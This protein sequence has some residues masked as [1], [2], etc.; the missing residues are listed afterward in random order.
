MSNEESSSKPVVLVGVDGSANSVKALRAAIQEAQ[1]RGAEVHAMNAWTYPY[2]YGME[3]AG[4]IV[5][6][7]TMEEAASAAL[8]NA[9]VEACPIEAQRASIQRFIV[10]GSPAQSLIAESKNAE[11]LVVGARGHGGF[12]GLL[13]GSV[14]SQVV[15]H[16]HCPVLVVPPDND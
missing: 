3:G 5:N 14:S 11:L 15:K 10:G 9:I 2:V 8:E 6:A 16:A 7:S 13:L 12:I 1:W 4:F